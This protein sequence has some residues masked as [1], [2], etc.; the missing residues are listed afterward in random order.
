MSCLLGNWNLVESNNWEEFLDSYKMASGADFTRRRSSV[1][2]QLRPSM[3]I[4]KEGEKWTISMPS[5]LREP[6]I[7][8]YDGVEFEETILDGRKIKCLIKTEGEKK[9]IEFQ[10]DLN[11]NNVLTT[12]I[13]EVI[14]EKLIQ[15]LISGDKV[16]TRIF[17]QKAEF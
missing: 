1:G 14:G 16:C 17:K 3:S 13:R 15:T 4:T 10:K 7:S 12:I 8:F 6:V 5:S 9:L 11:T 2:F